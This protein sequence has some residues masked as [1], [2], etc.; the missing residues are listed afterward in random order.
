MKVS[1]F[2]KQNVML[3]FSMVMCITLAAQTQ[4]TS[5]SAN[6]NP[7]SGSYSTGFGINTLHVNTGSGNTATGHSA[8]Y[9]NSSGGNNTVT[10]RA[11]MYANTTG[12]N[13]TA[14]GYYSMFLNTSGTANTAS[15]YFAL[16]LNGTGANNTAS[17]AQSLYSNT[18]GSSN[19]ANGYQALYGNTKS[20]GNAAVGYQ[21]LYTDSTGDYNSAVGYQALFR[22]TASGNTA[23]GYQALYNNTYGGTNTAMGYQALFG[24]AYGQNNVGIGSMA[25]YSSYEG[26]FNTAV[27]NGTLYSNTTGGNNTAVGFNAL[28]ANTSSVSNTAVGAGAMSLTTTGGNNTA[29]GLNA[30]A[31]NTTGT[32]NTSCGYGSLGTNHTGSFNSAFGYAANVGDYAFSNATAIGYGAI[33]DASNKVRIGNTFVTS[34]GG[35]VGWT[36]YSDS[37]VKKNIREGVPGLD[38]ISLLKPVMYNY[39]LAK[40]NELLGNKNQ[41][42]EWTGKNELEKINFSGFLAQEVDSAAQKIGY[43]F[44]GIDKTGTIMGLRYSDF[45]VPLVKAVQEQQQQIEELKKLIGSKETVN[46]E[47]YELSDKNATSLAQ[48]APNPFSGQTTIAYSI[49]ESVGK[50]QLLFYDAAGR[51]I[52]SHVISSKGK[53]LL[54]LN[55]GNLSAGTYSYTL[56]IDGKITDSKKLTRL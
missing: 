45:I 38:F 23:N 50:A 17:G 22:N 2:F 11:A 15:G 54:T 27:G 46:A 12:S 47:Q 51:L 53:G 28:Y 37:R 20:N 10:G 32:H 13:N 29:I 35:Q 19:T 42:A 31:T 14:N 25:L 55:S 48:N 7:I 34:I 18:I 56:V 49:P 36:I 6:T 33:A 44:S 39:D 43:N 16:F 5:Y 1:T 40:E 41:K 24:C 8:L 9:A 52:G 30:M 4:N 26:G 21:A 3:L